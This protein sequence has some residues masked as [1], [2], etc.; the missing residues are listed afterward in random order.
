[1]V[2]F[3]VFLSTGAELVF[4]VNCVPV[5]EIMGLFCF[6]VSVSV[7]SRTYSVFL[8]QQLVNKVNTVGQI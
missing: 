2:L 7:P 1:M 8:E 5:C 6:C 4:L 3:F